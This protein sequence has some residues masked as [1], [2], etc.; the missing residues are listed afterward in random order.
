MTNMFSNLTQDGLEKAEDRLGGNFSTLESGVYPAMIAMAYALTSDGGAKGINLALKVDVDGEER[1]FRQTVYVTKKTG[2]NFY[3]DKDKKKQPLPGFTV[4]DDLCLVATEGKTL[5]QITFEDKTIKVY[6]FDAKTEVNKNLP[7]AMDLLGKMVLVAIEKTIED[8]TTKDAAGVY[9]PTGET[10]EEN[11]IAKVAHAATRKTVS[12][13]REGKEAA[14]MDGWAAKYTGK[15][16]N[17]A[18]G[19]Q[20]NAGAPPRSGQPPKAGGTNQT[21]QSSLFNRG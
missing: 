11:Q 9:V 3:L 15:T 7:V 6:D 20:G 2:E 13:L 10:R 18:K 16:R 17:R 21:G 1:D 4:I 8:K 12:E 14:F 19:A 5:S